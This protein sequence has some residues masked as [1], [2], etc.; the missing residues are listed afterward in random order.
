MTSPLVRLLAGLLVVMLAFSMTVGAATAGA[1]TLASDSN[2]GND[3]LTG[4]INGTSAVADKLEATDGSE[5]DGAEESADATEKP[6]EPAE[7]SGGQAAD[8]NRSALDATEDVV[9]D[10]VENVTADAKPE[11]AA[12]GTAAADDGTDAVANETNGSE[13]GGTTGTTDEPVRKVENVGGVKTPTLESEGAVAGVANATDGVEATGGTATDAVDAT[14]ENASDATVAAANGTAGNAT[15]GAV[16]THEESADGVTNATGEGE[17][18][19]QTVDAVADESALGTPTETLV[20]DTGS[21][22]EQVVRDGTETTAR[23]VATTDAARENLT[24]VV[25]ET[26]AAIERTVDGA[27]DGVDRTVD[28]VTTTVDGDATETTDLVGTFTRQDGTAEAKQVGTS[29]WNDAVEEPPVEGDVYVMPPGERDGEGTGDTNP[30]GAS[31]NDGSGVLE[32]VDPADGEALLGALLVSGSLVATRTGMAA[33]TAGAAG[34]G[35]VP[36][37]AL[38]MLKE[39][40]FRLAVL[41]GYSRYDFDDPLENEN[42]ATVYE[43]VEQAPGINLSAVVEETGLAESTAR[44]H[45][46]VLEHESLVEAAKVRGRR[47]YVPQAGGDV[48]LVAA[49]EE[50]ATKEVLETLLEEEPATGTALADA[51]DRDKS[52]VSHHLSRLSEA[53]LVEREPDGPALM[54]S[55][56]PDVRQALEPVEVHSSVQQHVRADD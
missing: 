23:V 11:E 38:A 2:N 45:L 30:D 20:N 53:G 36:Q 50:E 54:N 33:S 31:E 32:G 25:E 35:T 4:E 40:L 43:T 1:Q 18:T 16:S 28:D 51:L 56:R 52:T 29:E 39:W 42:R 10:A 21:T 46:R 14:V 41:A 34:A 48:E 22:S 12:N 13:M 19:T 6:N 17:S 3:G 15:D 49:L 9:D 47:R 27:T 55:L 24:A 44:Y 5:P 7:R 37:L 8:R 26:A